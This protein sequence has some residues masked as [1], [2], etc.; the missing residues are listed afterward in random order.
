MKVLLLKLPYCR[1][2]EAAPRTDFRTSNSYRPMPSLALAALSGFLKAY[3]PAALE[4]ECVDSNLWGYAST[5][6]ERSMMRPSLEVTIKS[7]DYD[8]L[9]I[10]VPFSYNWR[11]LK[12]AVKF[13]QEHHPDSG[14][15][16]GGAGV[17]ALSAPQQER[18]VAVGNILKGEGEEGF[19]NR[20]TPPFKMDIFNL[21]QN[22]EA[23]PIPDWGAL[24]LDA[25]FA[26][27]PD[28]TLPIE[29]SRG[30]PYGCSYCTV[31][32]T[33]GPK[34]RYKSTHQVLREIVALHMRFGVKKVHFVDDN[35]S[36]NRE[37]FQHFLELFRQSKLPVQLDASNFSIK[38]LDEQLAELMVGCGF[39]RVSV[40]IE[41]ASPQIQRKTGKKLDLEKAAA[42]VK[43][44]KASGLQVHLCWMLGFPGETPDQILKTLHLAKQLKATSNQFLTVTPLPG[45]RLWAEAKEA[46]VLADIPLDA[47][48]CRGA[49]PFKNQEWTYDWLE[50]RIYDANIQCNFL[51][52]PLQRNNR[53]A[54]KA[55]LEGVVT[56]HP[57]HVIA[58]ILLGWLS[59]GAQRDALW[60]AAQ[61][62]LETE[63]GA[64]FKKYLDAA[65]P[66]IAA[67][68]ESPR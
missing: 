20:L 15:V 46:G 65:H 52:N 1:H 34:V 27:N 30:C 35:L 43:M 60:D 21:W 58:E 68:K 16:L 6:C 25:Y 23:L 31:T 50:E 19:L 13:H 7:R 29:A 17:A 56:N 51:G 36:F 59:T 42:Q 38:H 10:S 14:L 8:L 49:R 67:F 63:A 11:W 32:D 3:G 40:A 55:Y 2:P 24:D 66:A 57:G 39:K 37:W 44:L 45:T 47:L 41:S 61:K 4:I 48:D 18:G 26:A 62:H 54:F 53:L 64:V 33:W 28:R 9:G 5:S 22:L 12:D